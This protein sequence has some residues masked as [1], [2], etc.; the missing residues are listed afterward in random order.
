MRI[1]LQGTINN[2]E[3]LLELCKEKVLENAGF[4][5]G[6]IR[7]KEDSMIGDLKFI[8]DYTLFNLREE[9]MMRMIIFSI[10]T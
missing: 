9:R 10:I 2:W 1:N 6:V 8:D 5:C 4:L 3:K 7:D